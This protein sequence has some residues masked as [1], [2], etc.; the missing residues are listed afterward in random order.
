[1]GGEVR[2]DGGDLQVTAP[3]PLPEDLIASL[4]TEKPAVIVAL[5][6]P[7]DSAIASILGELRPN[8]PP[9]LRGLSDSRLLVMVNWSIMEAWLKT[10]RKLEEG[11]G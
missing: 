9:A 5:G 2:L 6:A 1:M 4:T 10:L 3:R 11:R 8:L 7:F